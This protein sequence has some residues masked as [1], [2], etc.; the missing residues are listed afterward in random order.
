VFQPPEGRLYFAGDYMSLLPGW[1][2]GAMNSGLR[3]VIAI[4][5]IYGRTLTG[6]P[7]STVGPNETS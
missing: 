4:A 1:M 6:L 7:M 5:A 2:E 3:A